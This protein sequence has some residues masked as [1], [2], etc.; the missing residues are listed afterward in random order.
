MIG[1][2]ALSMSMNAPLRTEVARIG[3]ASTR[4]MN[5]RRRS[6]LRL[7]PGRVMLKSAE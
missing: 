4:A 3:A 5:S 6:K 1:I 2:S 7:S